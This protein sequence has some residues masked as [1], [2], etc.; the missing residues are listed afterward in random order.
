MVTRKKG[1][2]D[3]KKKDALDQSRCIVNF[4]ALIC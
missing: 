2:K 3:V 1:K 4:L